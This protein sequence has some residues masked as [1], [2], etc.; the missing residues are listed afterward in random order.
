M[1]AVT[2]LASISGCR[3]SRPANTA[4]LHGAESGAL[5]REVRARTTSEGLPFARDLISERLRQADESRGDIEARVLR[6]TRDPDLVLP[7][8]LAALPEE[9]RGRV[10]L[11]IV[12]GSKM[13]FGR[14]HETRDCLAEA[15][16]AGR[17]MGFA[18][19]FIQTPERGAV[20]ANSKLLAEKINPVF[21]EYDHVLLIMLSK[22]AHDVIRY[23]QGAA[24]ELPP[25]HR[26]K[27]KSV[28]SLVGT[29]QGS[30]IADW[31]GNSP[32]PAPRLVRTFLRVTGASQ[33]IEMARTVGKTPWNGEKASLLDD[34][35]PN[36]IWTSVVA[37]PDGPDGKISE[38]LWSPRLHERL[39][40]TSPYYS[41][42]DGLVESAAA[43]L[44]DE[45]DVPEWI[46]LCYGSH[47]VPHDRY[48]DGTPVAPFAS[49]RNPDDLNPE[50][51]AEVMSAYLRAIPVSVLNRKGG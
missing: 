8:S 39:R 14:H 46:V 16:R 30:L 29:L 1:A 20:E 17:E 41:P 27:L 50:S 6:T 28:L 4:S 18:T 36:L 5:L 26:A 40:N 23:L 47:A 2:G 48:A 49:K 51:G 35:F 15:A 43:V 44:P 13:V 42:E 19:H 22:G 45:V 10:A 37:I 24:T 38:V 33:E 7:D 32:A 25:E 34:A 3:S 12:P 9:V 11:V 31:F 21:R